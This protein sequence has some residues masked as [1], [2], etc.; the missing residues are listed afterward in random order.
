[1]M[2]G[3]WIAKQLNVDYSILSIARRNGSFIEFGFLTC[4]TFNVKVKYVLASPVDLTDML[5]TEN[6]HLS[7]L[8]S[9]HLGYAASANKQ[10]NTEMIQCTY[11]YNICP[12]Y[13]FAFEFPLPFR[14]GGGGGRCDARHL[15]K[16]EGGRLPFPLRWTAF[17]RTLFSWP[18]PPSSA[19]HV[20]TPHTHP[21]VFVTAITHNDFPYSRTDQKGHI[22]LEYCWWHLRQIA[23]LFTGKYLVVFVCIL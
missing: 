8:Y 5:L 15:T 21:R 4:V 18:I 19:V 17:L 22:L 23:A 6:W 3:N 14:D 12:I 20:P 9:Q 11:F 16:G 1:M 10:A 2:S 13:F 7:S